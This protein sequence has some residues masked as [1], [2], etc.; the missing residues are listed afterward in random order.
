MGERLLVLTKAGWELQHA[1]FD[2][3]RYHERPDKPGKHILVY[4]QGIRAMFSG[5]SDKPILSGFNDGDLADR[6]SKN[7]ESYPAKQLINNLWEYFIPSEVD[8][9]LLDAIEK[10]AD[11]STR[12]KAINYLDQMFKSEKQAAVASSYLQRIDEDEYQELLD[13]IREYIH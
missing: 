1:F 10:G 12:Q 11:V 4:P 8:P 6:L 3:G 5:F 9:Y 7:L 13:F 2:E